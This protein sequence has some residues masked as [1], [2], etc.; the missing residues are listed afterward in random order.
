MRQERAN[1]WYRNTV[2]DLL[3]PNTVSQ[4]DEK[5]KKYRTI[6][7]VTIKI[8]EILHEKSL[9]PQY[10]QCHPRVCEKCQ[11]IKYEEGVLVITMYL[12]L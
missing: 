5:E 11:S 12:E 2:K 9:I 8:T 6:P 3:L 10:P 1:E 4:K 7:L